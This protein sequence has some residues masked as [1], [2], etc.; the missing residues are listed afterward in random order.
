MTAVPAIARMGRVMRFATIVIL[1]VLLPAVPA[2]AADTFELPPEVTPVLRAACEADVRRLCIV[3]ESTA[4]TVRRCVLSKFDQLNK[5]CQREI[6][7]AG[8]AP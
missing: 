1:L 4:G 7:A 3:P 6:R 5:D 8:L 2:T